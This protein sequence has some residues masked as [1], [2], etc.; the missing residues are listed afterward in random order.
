VHMELIGEEKRIQALFSDARIADEQIAPSFA[1]VWNRAQS[2]TYRPLRAFNLSFIAAS[3]LLVCALVSLAWW[4]RHWQRD[5]GVVAIATPA[6]AP[7]PETAGGENKEVSLP[8][9]GPKRIYSNAKSRGLK[10]AAR[11]EAL[12]VAANQKT[13]RD[14]K[15][16]ATWSSPTATLLDSTSSEL[17]KSLP[18]LNQT[19][20]ELKSFLPSQPK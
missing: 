1:G 3:A 8:K 20:D 15:A 10:L 6:L 16:I 11:H 5:P 9:P 18:Q 2:R 13:T 4:S 14:L 12:Q 17:L 19:V 7:V